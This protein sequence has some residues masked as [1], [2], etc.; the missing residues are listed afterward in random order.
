M[1]SGIFR[2]TGCSGSSP[3]SSTDLV[4]PRLALTPTKR[5]LTYI[6]LLQNSNG[7]GL[8]SLGIYTV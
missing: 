8:S 1:G 3:G 2:K 4:S 6:D 5:L 7:S